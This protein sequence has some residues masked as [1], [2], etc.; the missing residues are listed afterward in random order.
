MQLSATPQLLKTA[1]YRSISFGCLSSW[2]PDAVASKATIAYKC[3]QL[4][5]KFKTASKTVAV[6]LGGGQIK[7]SATLQRLVSTSC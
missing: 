4:D 5:T 1:N 3:L 6:F 7:L 2:R